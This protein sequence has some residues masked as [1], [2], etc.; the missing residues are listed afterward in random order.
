MENRL[1]N[2]AYKPYYDWKSGVG[3]IP[4]REQSMV[5]MRLS[6]QELQT[7]YNKYPDAY[8]N[9]RE[10]D[11]DDIFESYR[12]FGDDCKTVSFLESINMEVTNFLI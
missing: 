5:I 8:N 9:R 12:G 10:G 7:Y 4:S 1:P 11:T 6:S 2:P 3:S